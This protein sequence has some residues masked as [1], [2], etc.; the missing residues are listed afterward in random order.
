MNKIVLGGAVILFILVS[1]HSKKV[2]KDDDIKN[3]YQSTVQ[4][5]DMLLKSDSTDC[6]L[7]SSTLKII[8]YYD[9]I[10][11]TPCD[12]RLLPR[13]QYMMAEMKT[14]R[15]YLDF[16][17]I[18]NTPNKD[19]IS[20]VFEN[21]GFEISFYC[22]NDGDFKKRNHLPDNRFYHTFLLDENNKV[23]LCGS[24]T[25]HSKLW[26]VYKKTIF[27]KSDF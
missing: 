24:P 19:E 14:H 25:D 11:C 1:C 12:L 27:R 23:I 22:D 21:Y 8:V 4:W 5:T 20:T 2:K 18:F 15:S 17:F 6:R 13:W 26:D 3:F 16:I 10:G 9:S 7:N